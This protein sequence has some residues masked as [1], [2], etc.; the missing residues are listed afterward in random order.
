MR[1]RPLI[2]I[3]N[4][5]MRGRHYIS[6]HQ[7]GCCVSQSEFE[8]TFLNYPLI[9]AD[10]IK[11]SEKEKCFYTLGHTDTIRLLFVVLLFVRIEYESHEN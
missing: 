10:D 6:L 3:S 1:R 4:S 5:K 7:T 2:E 9:V 11:R 8:Q